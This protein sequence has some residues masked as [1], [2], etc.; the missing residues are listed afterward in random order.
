MLINTHEGFYHE[1]DKA[2]IA[3]VVLTR[4][5][6]QYACICCERPVIVLSGTI[7]AV[8]GLFVE[9]T[10]ETVLAGYLLHQ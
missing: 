8:E 9:Q 2:Q 5:V 3:Q 10:A 7:D 6:E 1:G 4:S